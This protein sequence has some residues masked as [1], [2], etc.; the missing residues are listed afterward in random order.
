MSVQTFT[1]PGK[2]AGKAR[3]RFRRES[4]HVY[5]PDPG[6]FQVRVAEH[7]LAAGLRPV[8]GPV[9]LVVRISR[10]MPQSWSKKRR[11]ADYMQPAPG[12]PDVNNVLGATL[13]GLSG[14]AYND[15]MQVFSFDVS[16]I[17]Q[18]F[19]STTVTVYTGADVLGGKR[20]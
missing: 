19:D 13:D 11:K 18:T 17:W 3:P 6:N 16:R 15:D 5:S 7:A 4:G 10:L 14:V 8:E 2:P 1:V 20:A 12:K 9:R